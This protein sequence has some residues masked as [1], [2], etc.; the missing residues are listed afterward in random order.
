MKKFLI[1]DTATK[2]SSISLLIDGNV[3]TTLLKEKSQ[4]KEIVPIIK[5]L[6][7]EHKL[8][9]EELSGIA[10]C[11]GPGLYTGTRVGV[12]TAKILSYALDLPLYPFTTFD[13]FKEKNPAAALDAKC[14][15][16]H[17]YRNGQITLI[18]HLDLE[19]IDSDVYCIDRAPFDLKK[20]LFETE[21]DLSQVSSIIQSTKPLKHNEIAVLYPQSES[22]KLKI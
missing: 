17:L 20:A 21:K 19:D 12:M 16:A 9:L 2:Q 14:K 4:T 10:V 5:T 1:I 22:D 13:L 3:F 18:D 15:R 11:I 8:T 6:L 7:S